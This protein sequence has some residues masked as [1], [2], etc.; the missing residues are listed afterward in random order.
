MKNRNAVITFDIGKNHFTDF[1]VLSFKKYCEKYDIDLIVVKQ[2]KYNIENHSNYNFTTY[3]KNQVIDYF[4]IYDRIMRIDIDTL[5]TPF[6]PNVFD[7][8]SGKI[9]ATFEDVGSRAGNR[10]N[11]QMKKTKSA[12]GDIPWSTGYF[13]SGVMLVDK[14]HKSIFE[15]NRSKLSHDL[16]D[17]REQNYVN[18]NS[19]KL[20]I[21]IHDW[22][23]KFNHMSMF[24]EPWFNKSR[25]ESYIIHYAGPASKNKSKIESD[26]N[27]FN[28]EKK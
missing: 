2:R 11:I 8:P 21:E 1:S 4:A 27:H 28:Y 16:G 22:G 12:L 13:N 17:M 14:E 20:N 7:L 25:R 3:E 5:I 19:N 6:C 26:F 24:E 23:Y 15:F 18:W 10:R 9:Y